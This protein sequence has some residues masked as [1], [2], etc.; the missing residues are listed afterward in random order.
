MSKLGY[1]SIH[2]GAATLKAKQDPKV[3]QHAQGQQDE[4]DEDQN[5]E[6]F[7]MIKQLVLRHEFP[8]LYS[9]DFFFQ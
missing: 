3:G 6:I 1:G 2:S 8:I 7:Q 9:L 4:K 5:L